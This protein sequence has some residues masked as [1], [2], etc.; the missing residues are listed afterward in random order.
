MRDDLRE[1]MRD[2]LKKNGVSNFVCECQITNEADKLQG[3]F[4]DQENLTHQGNLLLF[5]EDGLPI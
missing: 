5:G 2:D 1:K 3:D 4:A